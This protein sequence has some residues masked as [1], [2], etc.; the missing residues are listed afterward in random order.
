MTSNG[1]LSRQSE[2]SSYFSGVEEKELQLIQHIR[3][4]GL[5]KPRETS[6]VD[7]VMDIRKDRRQIS[8]HL[9][10]NYELLKKENAMLQRQAEQV[11]DQAEREAAGRI[12]DLVNMLNKREN[13]LKTLAKKYRDDFKTLKEQHQSILHQ[14]TERIK[15]KCGASMTILEQKIKDL[16]A[17]KQGRKE[18]EVKALATELVQ[19]EHVKMNREF[20]GQLG[21]YKEALSSLAQRERSLHH[22]MRQCEMQLQDQSS[23]LAEAQNAGIEKDKE[24][25]SWRRK[26]EAA[27]VELQRAHSAI[28]GHDIALLD[29]QATHSDQL[30]KL[31]DEVTRYRETL[32][33]TKAVHA[34]E[35]EEID[36]RVRSKLRAK[37]QM[38]ATLRVELK[39]ARVE[40]Q[41]TK[42]LIY[43]LNDKL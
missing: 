1:L 24:C 36:G 3:T 14:E 2:V 25:M 28:E 30:N 23:R 8:S 37:D 26:G 4:S 21:K 40:A 7:E 11:K 43:E 20:A 16:E 18:A 34:K 42:N 39:T 17:V 29:M 33:E 19:E 27:L 6:L 15:E 10:T 41:Q 13:D 5:R 38:I 35:L 32:A 9:T 31:R 22:Q 12:G